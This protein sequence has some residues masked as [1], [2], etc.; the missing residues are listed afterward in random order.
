M[1]DPQPVDPK[2]PNDALE[3]EE[4]VTPRQPPKELSV[5][6][7]SKPELYSAF[8]SF[9]DAG[10]LFIVSHDDFKLGEEV[11]LTLTLINEPAPLMV[12]GK[13]IWITPSGAQGGMRAGVGVQ[14]TGEDADDL[15][16]TIETH[17]A[18]M[19]TSDIRTD[20]M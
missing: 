12:E 4:S 2:A 10:G 17:L 6:L 7:L 8:L 16:H 1:D 3:S 15:R 18:G 14:F 13:V 19:L 5:E 20:T 9:V 11:I